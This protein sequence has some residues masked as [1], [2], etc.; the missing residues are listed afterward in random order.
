MRT[1]TLLTNGIEADGHASWRS[2]AGGRWSE[3]I[4]T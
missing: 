3:V 2:A 1:F 4:Q